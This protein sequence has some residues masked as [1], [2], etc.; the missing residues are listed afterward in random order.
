VD[1]DGALHA[2]TPPFV[3]RSTVGAGDALLAGFLAAGGEGGEALVEAV[4]WG[5]A[6]ARLPGSAGPSPAD[7]D[8]KSVK[9]QENVD[10]ERKLKGE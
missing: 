6:A 4:A 8:R 1:E 7:V 9:L 10:P 3:P 2:E 5:A